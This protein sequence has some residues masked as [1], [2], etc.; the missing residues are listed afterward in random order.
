MSQRDKQKSRFWTL[1]IASIRL[2]FH[3]VDSV[4]LPAYNLHLYKKGQHRLKILCP[5]A[6]FESNTDGSF[7]GGLRCFIEFLS[8]GPFC[9]F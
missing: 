8:Q 4:G 3:C 7:T 9:L 2:A 6:L 1:R 5:R